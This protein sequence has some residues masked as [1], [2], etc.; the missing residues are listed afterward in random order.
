[1][2]PPDTALLALALLQNQRFTVPQNIEALQALQRLCQEELARLW[3]QRSDS[4]GHVLVPGTY[5]EV[6]R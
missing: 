2:S 6:R 1:M 3:S 4:P 5:R